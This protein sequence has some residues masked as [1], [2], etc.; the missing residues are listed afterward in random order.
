MNQPISP[1]N[2]YLSFLI[3]APRMAAVGFHLFVVLVVKVRTL[4]YSMRTD[5]KFQLFV[6]VPKAPIGT[7]IAFGSNFPGFI[8]R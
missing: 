1:L 5:L 2:E 8:K 3:P 4:H 7:Y 6:L